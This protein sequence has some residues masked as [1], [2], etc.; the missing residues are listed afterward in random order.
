M[1]KKRKPLIP[2][3]QMYEDTSNSDR[4][5]GVNQQTEQK[6]TVTRPPSTQNEKDFQ[7]SGQNT[8]KNHVGNSLN[9]HVECQVCGKPNHTA[10]K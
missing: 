6:Q 10:I 3:G 5:K 9:H 4:Y 2:F 8:F 7:K 1:K